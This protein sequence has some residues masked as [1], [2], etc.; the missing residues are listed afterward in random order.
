MVIGDNMSKFKI[1]SLD[2]TPPT[3]GVPISRK[4]QKKKMDIISSYIHEEK[5]PFAAILLQ[6]KTAYKQGFKLAENSNY[7]VF[8]AKNVPS[9]ILLRD[10]IKAVGWFEI[11]NIGNVIIVPTMYQYLSLF[12]VSLSKERNVKKFS[13]EYECHIN[14]T[15][16]KSTDLQLI[17][18]SFPQTEKRDS[19][20][21]IY[22]LSDLSKEVVSKCPELANDKYSIFASDGMSFSNTSRQIGMVKEKMIKHCPMITTATI[23]AK[24]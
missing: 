10:D 2:L 4:K 15:K 8:T 22:H 11:P 16:E 14:P 17:G 7:K 13:N 19:F 12:S 5:D 6:G 9:A 20:V 21:D 23:K 1:M 18:G 24:K 3:L